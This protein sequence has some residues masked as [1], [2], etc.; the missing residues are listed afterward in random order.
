L[1]ARRFAVAMRRLGLE[2]RGGGAGALDCARF[3]VPGGQMS[4]F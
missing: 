2:R 4:L 3:A 1:L